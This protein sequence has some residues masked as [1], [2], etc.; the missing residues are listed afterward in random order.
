M[1]E[2]NVNKEFD[3]EGL[4]KSKSVRTTFKL[5]ISIQNDIEWLSKYLSVTQKELFDLVILN[6]SDLDN[7]AKAVQNGDFEHFENHQRITK[8]L[9]QAALEKLVEVSDKFDISRDVLL[10]LLILQLRVYFKKIIEKHVKIIP[11]LEEALS[12]MKNYFKQVE[13]IVDDQSDP[14]QF[15]FNIIDDIINNLISD[16]EDEVENGVP[17]RDDIV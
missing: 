14:A 15:R 4:K 2:D 3:I 12:D 7:W 5:P 10:S 6:K 11:I 16:I 8:V 1:L 9:S 13:D 17:L